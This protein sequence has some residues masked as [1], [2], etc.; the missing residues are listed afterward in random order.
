[1]QVPAPLQS[2]TI[3]SENFLMP[4]QAF[5]RQFTISTMAIDE[6]AQHEPHVLWSAAGHT[7]A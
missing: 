3:C 1:M 6:N 2:K 5:V 7:V 4:C